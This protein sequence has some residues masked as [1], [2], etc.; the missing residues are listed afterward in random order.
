MTYTV[1]RKAISDAA[2]TMAGVRFVHQGRSVDTGVDCMGLLAVVLDRVG[3]TYVDHEGY[4]RT[5]SADFIREMM[6]FNFDEIPLDDV[7]VGDIYLMRMGGIKPKHAAIKVTGQTDLIRGV[8]PQLVHASGL[9][10]TGRVVIEPVRQRLA[11]IVTAFRL[12]G[13]VD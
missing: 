13:L 12:R 9:G 1:T 7:G 10:T 6:L 4:R 3:Y 8:E 11:S 2:I 5:P